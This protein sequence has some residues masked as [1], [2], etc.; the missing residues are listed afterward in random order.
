M[1]LGLY[2]PA[3][4][5][6][7]M[8]GI[9]I[10]QL[11]PAQFRRRIGYVAQDTGLLYGTLRSNLTLAAPWLSEEAIWEGIHR[12]G[13][14]EMVQSHPAGIDLPIAEGGRSLSGGQRQLV[15]LAR[16]LMLEPEIL[17]FDEPTSAMD[18]GTEKLFKSSVDKYLAEDERRMLVV[19]THKRSM[20][21]LVDRLIALDGGKVANDGPKNS[22]LANKPT[23]P[24]SNPRME[25]AEPPSATKESQVALAS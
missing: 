22:V 9:D 15:C 25:V 20:L 19:A 7:K 6:V 5:T 23:V 21:S 17:I 13:L 12:A 18:P 24:A 10:R 8:G 3:E 16:A 11:S 14:M 2:E 1:L 4:G